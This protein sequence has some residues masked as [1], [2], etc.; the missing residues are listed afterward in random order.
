MYDPKSYWEK[1]L[2]SS[3]NLQ[4]V[5]HIS[6]SPNYNSWLYRKKRVCIE[7][8]LSSVSLRGKDV[9]DIGC[10]T[11]FFVDW[12]LMSGANVQGVDITEISIQELRRRHNAEFITQDISAADFQLS[13]TFDVVNMWDVIYH[14]VDPIS[15]DR[16]MDNISRL[17]KPGGLFLFTDWFGA[18]SDVRVADHVQIRSLNTYRQVLPDKGFELVSL[19]PLYSVLNK[20]HFPKLDNYLA[21]LY[22]LIDR[23]SRTV[24]NNNLSLSVWRKKS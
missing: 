11:G 10:G 3:F 20:I 18:P 13:K 22:F 4:G 19:H 21:P 6:F 5:G 15:F 17:V 9:L 2:T 12:Y 24:A 8:A 23:F 14:I 1:R 16:A 7:S